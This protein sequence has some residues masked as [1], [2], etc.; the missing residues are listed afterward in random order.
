MKT[1]DIFAKIDENCGCEAEIEPKNHPDHEVSMAKADLYRAANTAIEIHK[2]LKTV[3]EQQGLE[4]WVQAKITK[5]ADYL[6][7]VH[8]YLDYE[9]RFEEV[10]DQ[11]VA[12]GAVGKAVGGTVGALAGLATSAVG[13]GFPHKT[14]TKGAKIGAKVGDKL[15]NILNPV[16]NKKKDKE[17]TDEDA[18]A[19]ATA[20]GAIATSM[21]GGNGFK[22]GGPG[23]IIR[24]K[25]K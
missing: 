13:G 15:T 2:L 24:R 23:T 16:K 9:M 1:T 5:A 8:N 4:G 21:G 7:S 20:S 25:K 12:E 3:S 6:Q 18:S 11:G 19:G 10:A 17:E 14:M 22:N